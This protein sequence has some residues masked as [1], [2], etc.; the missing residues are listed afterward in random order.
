[1]LTI[2]KHNLDNDKSSTFEFGASNFHS[3]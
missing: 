2:T 1:V 3:A